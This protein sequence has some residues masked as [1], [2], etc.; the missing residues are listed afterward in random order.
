MTTTWHMTKKI[1]PQVLTEGR[2]QLHYAIQFIAATGTALAEAL[3]DYSHTSLSWHPVLEVFVGAAIRAAQPFQVALDPVNLKLILLNQ[4][5]EAIVSLPLHGKTMVEG[6][7][8]LQQAVSQLGADASK[9][10]FLDYPPDDFP[11]HPL[12]HGATFDASQPSALSELTDYYVNTYLLFQ[13]I[14]TANEDATAIRIWPHHFD[15]ATLIMLPGTRNGSAL[16]VGVGLSPG[17]ANY[18]EPYWYVSPYPYPDTASLPV[19]DGHGFWHTQH[20]VGAVLPASQLTE[21]SSVEAQQQQVEAFLQ[22]ALALSISL[23]Q[24]V[25]PAKV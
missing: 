15:M 22:S 4:Q 9:I 14:I 24:P 11:D 16:T 17:D 8:W 10:A 23:L 7:S 1:K 20:W 18:N 13:S 5:S 12:A 3:P 6:L 2:L 25:S 21:F 19:L